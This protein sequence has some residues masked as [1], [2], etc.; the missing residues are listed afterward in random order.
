MGLRAEDAK[1][2]ALARATASRNGGRAAAAVRDVTG[3]TYTATAVALR[4]L[5]LSAVQAAVAAAVASGAT[6]LES[7][8]V[9]GD[10]DPGDA[11]LA[12]LAELGGAPL[13]VA[14]ADGTLRRTLPT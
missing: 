2:V 1:L 3:R 12:V 10:P 4:S 8:V 6:A 5:S 11:D 13:H 14:A 9:V 7:A